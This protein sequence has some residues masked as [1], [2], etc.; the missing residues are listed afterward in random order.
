[1][2]IFFI[3]FP[4]ILFSEHTNPL[5]NPTK[6]FC[7][8]IK[9]PK[10]VAENDL[11]VSFFV[12]I[13]NISGRDFEDDEVLFYIGLY[14][15]SIFAR[16]YK[17][18]DYLYKEFDG[19]EWFHCKKWKNGEE[20]QI[21]VQ[22]YDLTPLQYSA[23]HYLPRENFLYLIIKNPP[24]EQI[25]L[26]SFHFQTIPYTPNEGTGISISVKGPNVVLNGDCGIFEI[27]IKNEKNIDFKKNK[28]TDT[29]E[30]LIVFGF[31]SGDGLEISD[32]E[33]LENTTG[34]ESYITDA[35]EF[36]NAFAGHYVIRIP[37]GD[38]PKGKEHRIKLKIKYNLEVDENYYYLYYYYRISQIAC[39]F[40]H[41]KGSDND[42]TVETSSGK[43][44]LIGL[45]PKNFNFS[46]F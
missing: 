38:F 30:I 1:M 37:I 35:S 29:P 34:N 21:E 45:F 2:I 4:F 6:N 27:S 26:N 39:Y 7:I 18:D 8:S 14:E 3:L 32:F 16:R 17:K 22:A 43:D 44:V 24:E 25:F 12:S 42:L 20:R 13:E 23:F 9:G 10:V 40:R 33:I 36:P 41:F 5:C 46:N 31:Q 28:S 15:G 11:P 19:R